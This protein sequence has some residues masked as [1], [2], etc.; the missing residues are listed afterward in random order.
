MDRTIV[1]PGSIPLDTDLLSTNLNAMVALG[2]LVQAALGAGPVVDGLGCSPTQPASMVVTIGPGSIAAM[3][4]VD[5]LAYGSLPADPTDPLM[6]MGI[7]LTPT[8]FTLTAPTTSGQ[9]VN[10]LI[11]AALQESDVNPV[12]LPYYN[13]SNPAQPYSGPN[14]SGTAQNTQRIQRVQLELKSG[15]PAN[16]GA[17]TTPPVDNGWVGLYVITVGYGQTQ[18]TSSSIATLPGAPFLAYKLPALRPGYATLQSFTSSGSFTVPA[19][20]TQCKVTVIGGGGGG[21]GCSPSGTNNLGAASG[22]AGGTAVKYVKGLTPGMVIP[23][24]VGAG[25]SAG[26]ASNGAG[27]NGGT[28]SF[29][30]Y[31]S[32][33]GGGGGAFQSPVSSAGP[34]GGTAVGGDLNVQGQYGED[35]QS[36]TVVNPA[37]GGSTGHGWGGRGGDGGGFAGTGYGAGGG[38]AYNV[39]G[40]GGAGAPGLVLV[41][42]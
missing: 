29:G 40:P 37:S 8:S 18:V 36:N 31:C 19:G 30:T 26:A 22:A 28:S 38:G 41:E 6:K 14:N 17:Q 34:A 4:V 3:E 42:Y 9:S 25:G 24:T 13:A 33:I 39:S 2:F 27:G 16:T 20:V 10:Y 23:V 7:N 21:G 32:A 35:G 15:T 5:P 12:V 1:Y 11:Q